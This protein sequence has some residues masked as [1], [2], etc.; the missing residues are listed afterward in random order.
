MMSLCDG[1]EKF[2]RVE[3]KSF[4]AKKWKPSICNVS[5]EESESCD[6]IDCDYN[7]DAECCVDFQ[8]CEECYSNKQVIEATFV[9]FINS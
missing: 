8:F 6:N 2:F 3:L 9:N 4:N 5:Y 7:L 1:C